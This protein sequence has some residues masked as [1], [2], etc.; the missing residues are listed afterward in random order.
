VQIYD[1]GRAY[2]TTSPL[3]GW[4]RQKS[5]TEGDSHYWGLWWGMDSIAAMKHKI[6][7]FMSEFGMQAMPVIESINQFAMPED[8]DTS[9]AVMRTH[10]KHPTGFS[11]LNQYL[12]MEKIPVTDFMSFVDGTQELQTRALETA[13][14]AQRNSKQ[15]CMGTLIWQFNDC[16]PVCSWSIIDYYGRKKKSYNTVQ[17]LFKD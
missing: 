4:G 1:P 17:K 12:L 3:Y 14:K 6:P 15:R 2:I 5:M 7:R 11:T 9:S 10:Q 13:I 8:M 16:W